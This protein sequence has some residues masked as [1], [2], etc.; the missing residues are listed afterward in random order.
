[1]PDKKEMTR[2]QAIK[3]LHRLAARWPKSLWVFAASGSFWVMQCGPDDKRKM[4]VTSEGYDPNASLA[5][6][7]IPCDGGDW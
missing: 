6:I 1:M 4:C 5:K 3:E 2:V 7:D